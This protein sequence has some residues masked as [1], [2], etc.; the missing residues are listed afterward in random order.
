MQ[1]TLLVLYK[2]WDNDLADFD[3]ATRG[4][5]GH[6][7]ALLPLRNKWLKIGSTSSL[8]YVS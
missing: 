6:H 7:R 3:R 5:P 4:Q 1:E 8:S 2:R